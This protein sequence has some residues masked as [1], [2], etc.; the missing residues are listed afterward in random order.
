MATKTNF[1]KSLDLQKL[2]TKTKSNNELI[3][4]FLGRARAPAA[5]YRNKQAVRCTAAVWK[6]WFHVTA[7]YSIETNKAAGAAAIWL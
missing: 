4:Y 6:N 3:L 7:L 1:K 2:P 5:L